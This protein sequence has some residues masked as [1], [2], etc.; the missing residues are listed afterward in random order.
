MNY[1]EKARFNSIHRPHGH[2]CHENTRKDL[3]QDIYDWVDGEDERHVFWLNG[4]AGTG[5]STIAQ[6][7]AKKYYDASQRRLAASF[8]F[9]RGG[10]DASHVGL[11]V[12][13]IAVQLANDI[14]ILR[15]PICKAIVACSDITSR[16]LDDQWRRLVFQPFQCLQKTSNPASYLIV[17]DALDECDGQNDIWLILKLIFEA[18]CL[19]PV[20]LRFF[21]T[22]R[23]ETAIRRGFQEMPT[24]E[25]RDVIL[26]EIAPALVDQDIALYLN[27][28]LAMIR[29][30]QYLE[31]DWPIP[32]Q[33]HR[34]V[35]QS[36]G[37]FIWAATACRYIRQGRNHAK[38]R[39][40]KVLQTQ[41]SDLAP[42]K[43]LDA[44]YTMVLVNSIPDD[45]SEE[46]KGASYGLLSYILE[47]VVVLF[48]PLSTQAIHWLLNISINEIKRTVMDLHSI[49]YMPK[50]ESGELRLH[51][52]SFRDF[53][54]NKTRCNHEN[55]RVDEK[56][57][58]KRLLI[59]CLRLMSATL[60]ENICNLDNPGILLTEVK[61]SD[62]WHSVTPEVQYACLYWVQH[63]HR[64]SMMI[65][66]GD[67][68]DDFVRQHL[69]HW[70]E[71]LSWMGRAAESIQ[72]V[73]CLQSIASV[74]LLETF[75]KY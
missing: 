8:F 19:K 14:P 44:I 70:L 72:A 55:L 33:V 71:V 73:I 5:K 17:I 7:V 69:L 3:L 13:S 51:H 22:S 66:D 43:E 54:V 4:L 41:T 21:L 65:Y 30:E 50:E 27:H 11:F 42:E 58:H 47:S 23:P 28:E 39:L 74:S 18:R 67:Q 6:T 59:N 25:H 75:T 57:A 10:G 68:V 29:R 63:L 34:L 38:E 40:S 49:L 1:S 62:I 9:S 53:L 64:S 48:T 31:P 12:M 15:E 37:L 46:E 36:S 61:Q 20:R 24:V 56:G 26:H 2:V 45:L 16:S 35:N 52:P 32:E 60:K